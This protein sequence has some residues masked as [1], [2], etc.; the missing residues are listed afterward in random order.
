MPSPLIPFPRVKLRG[1]REIERVLALLAQPGP[2]PPSA[3][4]EIRARLRPLV[5]GTRE[6]HA[7]KALFF[8]AVDP[9]EPDG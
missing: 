8:Q 1:I 2:L 5:R 3:W 7:L 4:L 9:F 6:S